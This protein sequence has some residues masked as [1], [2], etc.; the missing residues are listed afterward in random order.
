MS[1]QIMDGPHEGAEV[2]CQSPIIYMLVKSRDIEVNFDNNSGPELKTIKKIPYEL[3]TIVFH[4]TGKR[5]TGYW[6]KY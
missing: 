1:Y 3:R 4:N 2:T 5:I 6:R